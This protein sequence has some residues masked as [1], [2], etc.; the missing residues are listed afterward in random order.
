M[1]SKFAGS[2]NWGTCHNWHQSRLSARCV[3]EGRMW[4]EHTTAHSAHNGKQHM[5]HHSPSDQW[6]TPFLQFAA[7]LESRRISCSSPSIQR[8][9][10]G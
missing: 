3:R 4:P 5:H 1:G 10:R 8:P 9:L 6:G 7:K 2:G